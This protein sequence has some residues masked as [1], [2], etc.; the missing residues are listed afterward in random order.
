LKL[1]AIVVAFDNALTHAGLYFSI[2]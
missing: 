1:P 2:L